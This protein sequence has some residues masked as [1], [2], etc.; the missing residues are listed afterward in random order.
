MFKNLQVTSELYRFNLR[1]GRVKVV[2]FEAD[3]VIC[4]TYCNNPLS[5]QVIYILININH[6]S[7]SL[8]RREIWRRS[9]TAT[10]ITFPHSIMIDSNRPVFSRAWIQ[11]VVL[12]EFW[13]SV[14]L[15]YWFLPHHFR[16]GCIWASIPHLVPF[17]WL[18]IRAA[19]PTRTTL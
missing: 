14:I 5:R 9:P 18:N 2:W 3:I 17:S 19:Y 12:C 13:P 8:C 4:I 11:N 6:S 1:M 16:T 10:L 7:I 15:S